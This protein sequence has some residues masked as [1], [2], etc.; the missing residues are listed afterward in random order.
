MIL[1]EKLRLNRNWSKRELSRRAGIDAAL[2]TLAE[3]RGLR[4]YPGQLN[5]IASAFEMSEDEA[6]TLLQEVG[7]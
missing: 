5:K 6:E 3:Q 4:L 7:D 2:L 1:L